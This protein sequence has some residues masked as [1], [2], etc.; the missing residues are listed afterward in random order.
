MTGYILLPGKS[1]ISWKSKKLSTISRSSSEA[2]YRAMIAA[3]SEVCWLVRLLTELG[4]HNLKP[5]RLHCDNQSAIYIAKNNVFHD[6]TKHIK[7]DCHFTR[8]RF[9]RI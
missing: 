7:I 1:P 8:T 3:A 6:K 2:E 5:I 9:Y 4:M